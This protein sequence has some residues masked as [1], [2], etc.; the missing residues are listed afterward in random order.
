M[1]KIET[2]NAGVDERRR[3]F[4]VTAGK[5]NLTIA[6]DAGHWREMVSVSLGNGCDGP[7]DHVG[8]PQPWSLPSV[9]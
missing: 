4:R 3:F 7:H 9:R 6:A 5:A 2:D 1:N 8:V